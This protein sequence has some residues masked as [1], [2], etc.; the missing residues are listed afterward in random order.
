MLDCTALKG[1]IATKKLH[2][3]GINN[4][5]IDYRMT[6][7]IAMGKYANRAI[8]QSFFDGKYYLKGE[9]EGKKE[10]AIQSSNHWN[11]FVRDD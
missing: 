8:L 1:Y 4:Q 11:Q 6:N 3:T 5:S 2:N 9:K 10:W 7:Y